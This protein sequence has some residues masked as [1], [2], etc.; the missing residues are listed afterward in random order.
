MRLLQCILLSSTI[1]IFLTQ[2]TSAT[3]QEN[4][5]D[6]PLSEQ[7]QQDPLV[8]ELKSKMEEVV[9]FRM[10]RARELDDFGPKYAEAMIDLTDDSPD[11]ILIAA[12]EKVG[13]PVGAEWLILRKDINNLQNQLFEKYS[14]LNQMDPEELNNILYG[15]MMERINAKNKE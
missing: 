5:A 1:L 13:M 9:R 7:L 3:D 8:E 11:E 10:H 15:D 2:C 4:Q 6:L 12:W 14:D